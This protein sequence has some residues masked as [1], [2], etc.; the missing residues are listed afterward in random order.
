MEMW[1]WGTWLVGRV[2]WVGFGDLSDLFQP[3]WFHDPMI[4]ASWLVH[5]ITKISLHPKPPSPSYFSLNHTSYPTANS[6]SNYS[7]QQLCCL[8]K[9]IIFWFGQQDRNANPC[10][11]VFHHLSPFL[12]DNRQWFQIAHQW[13]TPFFTGV[14]WD[15][16]SYATQTILK[17]SP[18]AF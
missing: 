11:L 15:L 9:P 14:H 12:W 3:Q 18:G 2:G 4:S 6:F 1:H 7:T 8:H 10:I 13:S 16:R 5:W 17:M